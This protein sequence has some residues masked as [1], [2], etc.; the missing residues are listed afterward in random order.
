MLQDRLGFSQRRA[1]RLVGQHRSTHRH[2]PASGTVADPDAPVREALRVFALA[3][4]RWGHRRALVA[5][6]GDGHRINHKRCQRLWREEGLR[7]KVPVRRKRPGRST[8]DAFAADAPN[9]VWAIDFQFDAT[10]DGRPF[11]IANVIDE[12]TREALGGQVA[13][14]V[15][16]DDLVDHLT[17][18][19]R[20]RGGWPVAIR[21]D[22][23]PELVS[24]TLADWCRG[25]TGL[26]F[27]DPGSP[28]QNPYVESFHGRLRDEC[29]NLNHFAM[30]LE[31]K[32]VIDD[33]RDEYNRVRPHSALSY[34]PPAQYAAHCTHQHR[35]ELS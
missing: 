32:V 29:L 27:I 5:L 28:W 33:W 10:T 13:R 19:A 16:A 3:H 6:R 35:S 4:P 14:S 31:A 11:K 30:L 7:V 8:T 20:Q 15:T 22:N 21:C 17:T 1:C 9:V 26:R 24:A 23:G 12:H 25:R 18:L 2:Q 34:Q